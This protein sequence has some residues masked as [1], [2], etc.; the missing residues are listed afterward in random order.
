MDFNKQNRFKG[1]MRTI[2]TPKGEVSLLNPEP[3]KLATLRQH[4]PLGMVGFPKEYQGA[5]GGIVM[6]CGD[7]EALA[8]K[9]QGPDEPTDFSNEMSFVYNL[10][11]AESLQGYRQLGF[12]GC[13]MPCVYAREKGDT[14]E[15]GFAY[16]GGP[17]PRGIESNEFPEGPYDDDFGLGFTTMFTHFVKQLQASAKR[18]DLP[19]EP[20]IGLDVRTR[21]Q[22]GTVQFGFLVYSGD[23]YCLKTVVSE[24]DPTWACLASKGIH[25]VYHMPSVPFELPEGQLKC[26]KPDE[27]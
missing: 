3:A 15:V 1:K 23:I 20:S 5:R 10:L 8:I 18:T 2:P 16:F 13:L 27:G 19:L 22:L 9:Q 26:A 4:L 25:E 6:K 7:R 24:K 14:T 12:S 17:S 21:S 11:I